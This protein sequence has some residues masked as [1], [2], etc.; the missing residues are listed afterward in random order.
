MT[1]DLSVYHRMVGDLFQQLGDAVAVV[2]PERDEGIGHRQDACQERDAFAGQAVRVA[3]AVHAFVMIAHH[4]QSFAE[5]MVQGQGDAVAIHGVLFDDV[6]LRRVKL[7]RFVQDFQRSADL[8]DIVQIAPVAQGFEIALAQ[9]Q[10][11]AQL[12]GDV[13]HALRVPFGIRILGFDGAG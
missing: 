8:A 11:P 13:G 6:P 1:E 5:H 4:V 9:V 3:A 7:T 10:A 2:L 12:E